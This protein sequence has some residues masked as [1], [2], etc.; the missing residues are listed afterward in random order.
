MRYMEWK[1]GQLEVRAHCLTVPQ[2]ATGVEVSDQI[3]YTSCANY[4][5]ATT[6][7]SS[8]S[9]AASDGT[10]HYAQHVVSTLRRT[11]EYKSARPKRGKRIRTVDGICSLSRRNI[12]GLLPI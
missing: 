6:G 5:D 3:M 7:E 10:L 11:V 9:V 4:E 12:R 8:I 1:S 2:I